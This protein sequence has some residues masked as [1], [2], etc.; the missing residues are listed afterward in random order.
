MSAFVRIETADSPQALAD[1]LRKT[2]EWLGDDEL[3][4]VFVE[5]VGEVL[6]PLRF[7]NADRGPIEQLKEGN[8][9]LAE[10]A[11]QWTE[12]WFAEGRE[13]GLREGLERGMEQGLEHGRRDMAVRLTR[14]KFGG[15]AA[16]QL[17]PL[18]DRIAEADVL[19]EVGDWVIQSSGA[20]DLLARAEN[21]ANSGNGRTGL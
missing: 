13:S 8:T 4:P 19:A 9:M 20:A 5:W 17:A 6:M 11:K 1:A 15:A 16:E 3:G 10:R 12:Q 7:P 18:L 21:A 2:L 14:L